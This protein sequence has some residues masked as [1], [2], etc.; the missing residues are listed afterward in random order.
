M[1]V[2]RRIN[3]SFKPIGPVLEVWGRPISYKLKRAIFKDS[4]FSAQSPKAF[5]E[6]VLTDVRAIGDSLGVQWMIR[7][8]SETS[9]PP[10]LYVK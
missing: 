4:G 5:G 1:N 10:P 3:L 7:D 6:T 2:S 9:R 8:Q